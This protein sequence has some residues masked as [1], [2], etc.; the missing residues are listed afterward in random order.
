VTYYPKQAAW[1]TICRILGESEQ[2]D[3]TRER[4]YEGPPILLEGRVTDLEARQ[5]EQQEQESKYKSRQLWFNFLLVIV[6]AATVAVYAYQ[7]RIMVQALGAAKVSADAARSAAETADNSLKLS[8]NSLRATSAGVIVPNVGFQQGSG[9]VNIV[10]ENRGKGNA[11]D[12]SASYRISAI[13]LPESKQMRIYE[14]R[15]ASHPVIGPGEGSN[16]FTV[17]SPYARD[18]LDRFNNSLEA[19]KVEG[20]YQY[21]NSFTNMPRRNF[22]LIAMVGNAI[23]CDDL[24]MRLRVNS[25]PF[26]LNH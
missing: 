8:Q 20:T 25:D 19:I 15:T 12:V 22:C 3:S 11:W 24:A 21:G 17:L 14:S 1:D 26:H 9:V 2:N 13:S 6:G 16:N 4:H 7:A 5:R 10:F 18:D 23:Q